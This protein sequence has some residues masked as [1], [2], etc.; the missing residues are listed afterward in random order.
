M[1]SINPHTTRANG[2]ILT[3]TIYNSDHTN[4]VGNAQALNA[5]KLESAATPVVDGEVVVYDGTSATSVRSGGGPP[6]LG[7]DTA[8]DSNLAAFDG[9]TGALLKD[10]GVPVAEIGIGT[11]TNIASAATT[12][13]ATVTSHHAN[14]T[15]TTTITSFGDSGSAARPIYL[16]RFAGAL[17][18]THNAASLICPDGANILTAADDRAWVEDLGSN[19][20]RIIEL[21][22]TA[23]TT[24]PGITCAVGLV[25]TN[26]S[27]TPATQIDINAAEVVL[28]TTTGKGI[29]HLAVDLTVNAATTGA[30]AL[31]AGALAAN[32]WYNLFIISNGVTVAGLASLSATAPTMPSGYV[33]KMR[34]GAMKTGGS[35]TFLRN[36]IVGNRAQYRVVSGSTTPNLPIM[37]SGSSGDTGTP[38]WTAIAVGAYVPPTAVGIIGSIG[39]GA[40]GGGTT[41]MVAPNDDYGSINSATNPPPVK[42]AL[43]QNGYYV[44]LQFEFVLETT[45]IYYAA[46]NFSASHPFVT[47]I[48][49]V[50]AVNAS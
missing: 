10:S 34:V 17:Q 43:A 2:T 21:V 22:R 6:V 1:T 37:A 8:V 47:C 24:N 18:I 30:N 40:S 7:P 14:I 46:E 3:A 11:R 36:R 13:L 4:H 26:N 35:S 44:N 9:T 31:D 38:T 29:S 12:S 48:G 32:T 33:Y 39:G 16:V 5:D 28:R 25:V 42:E 50:D 20:W 15:G 19:N 23:N 45:N 41:F 49:W 27:G